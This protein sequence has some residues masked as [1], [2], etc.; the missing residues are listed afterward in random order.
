M[1]IAI[2]IICFSG[3]CLATALA[4][5]W[6]LAVLVTRDLLWPFPSNIEGIEVLFA[7]WGLIM[8]ATFYRSPRPIWMPLFEVSS[9]R[10][11]VTRM[12]LVCSLVNFAVWLLV[13]AGLSA[14][15]VLGPLPWAFCLLASAATLLNA[16]YVAV[17]WAFRPENLFSERF[18]RFADDPIVFLIFYRFLRRRK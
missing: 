14:T 8:F 1:K 11:K 6:Y 2:A 16:I 18:R 12:L 10:V 15:Q 4:V 13:C 9:R 7:V 17:H 5:L 3:G